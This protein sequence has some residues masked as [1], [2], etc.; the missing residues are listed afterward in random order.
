MVQQ[1]GREKV[2][3][4]KTAW[5]GVFR[6]IATLQLFFLLVRRRGRREEEKGRRSRGVQEE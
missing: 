6:P 5:I 2:L 4:V 1:V 3:R